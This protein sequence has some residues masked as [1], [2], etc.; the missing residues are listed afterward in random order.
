[1]INYIKMKKI[2]TFLYLC[3]VCCSLYAQKLYIKTM[4]DGS[5]RISSESSAIY[6]R[7]PYGAGFRLSCITNGIQSHFYLCFSFNEG[8]VPIFCDGTTT[9]LNKGKQIQLFTADGK[10]YV[11]KTDCDLRPMGVT[12]GVIFPMYLISE[13]V[14]DDLIESNVTKIKVETNGGFFERDIIDNK[15]CKALKKYYK[16]IS[17]ELKR[18]KKY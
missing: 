6:A 9:V 16:K 18:Q 5:E 7:V 17:K 3:F 10:S 13:S 15:I 2:F 1:M 12:N 4:K 14:I 8:L 11:F